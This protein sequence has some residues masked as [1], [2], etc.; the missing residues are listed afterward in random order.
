LK[1][2]EKATGISNILF[3]GGTWKEKSEDGRRT[4]GT[5]LQDGTLTLGV[6]KENSVLGGEKKEAQGTFGDFPRG[7]EGGG[8]YVSIDQ[9]Q[10]RIL[11]LGV[12]GGNEIEV[13]V[14]SKE[15]HGKQSILKGGRDR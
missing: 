3:E 8:E 5:L 14:A 10:R 6:M 13:G 15:R 4:G 11:W 12:F 9:T 1:R 2:K 7:G